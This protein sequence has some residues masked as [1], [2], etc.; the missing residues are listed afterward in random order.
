MNVTLSIDADLVRKTRAYA[1]EHKTTLGKMIRAYLRRVVGEMTPQEAAER[2]AEIA[3]TQSGRSPK[4][5]RFD[6]NTIHRY[7]QG[8][9]KGSD[10]RSR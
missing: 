8:M 5:W 1:R 7:D 10:R 9:R 2:F 6:R 4:G 3:R